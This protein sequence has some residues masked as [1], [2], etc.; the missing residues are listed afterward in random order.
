MAALCLAMGDPHAAG[1]LAG[2]AEAARDELGVTVWPL[3]QSLAAQL[4]Q[5]VA[6]AL[7]AEDDRRER[8]A[9]AEAGPWTALDE[10]LAVLSRAG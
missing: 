9:G 2:A 1:R 6:G 5:M 10:G 8:E 4:D 3:L 7:G